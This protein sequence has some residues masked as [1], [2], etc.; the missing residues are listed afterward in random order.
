MA[1]LQEYQ[2]WDEEKRPIIKIQVYEPPANGF[3]CSIE[4][5]VNGAAVALTDRQIEFLIHCLAAK[6]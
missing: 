1:G 4:D 6:A 2:L 3:R 5:Q